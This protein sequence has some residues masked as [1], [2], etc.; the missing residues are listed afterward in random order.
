AL[1]AAVLLKVGIQA[2]VSAMGRLMVPAVALELLAVALGAALLERASRRERAGLLV[3]AAAVAGLL[4]A[5]TPPLRALARRKDEAPLPIRRFP[6]ALGNGGFAECTVDAGRL[7][8]I[9]WGRARL[10]LAS[11]SPPPGESA[12]VTCELPAGGGDRTLRLEDAYAPSGYT[13]RVV[14]RVAADG[15]ELLLHDVGG[16]EGATWLSVPLGSA[17]R[18]TIEILAIRPDPGWAWGAASAASFEIGKP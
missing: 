10:S 5:A 7:A 18:V 15:R 2:L 8:A 6:L 13:G 9:E 12:R 11:E 3:L 16:P 1:A 17:R 14:D 4:L